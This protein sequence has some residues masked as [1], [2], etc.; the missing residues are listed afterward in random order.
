MQKLA[1][2]PL[3]EE[4]STRILKAIKTLNNS[5]NE[6][7]DDIRNAVWDLQEKGHL[8]KYFPMEQW[9]QA[10]VLFI[11]GGVPE[12]WMQIAQRRPQEFPT[13]KSFEKWPEQDYTMYNLMLSTIVSLTDSSLVASQR[14]AELGLVSF[15]VDELNALLAPEG[16][17]MRRDIQ[18]QQLTT[19][20]FNI[21]QHY[22][23]AV[24]QLREKGGVQLFT[25]LLQKAEYA[26][27]AIG[28][29]F[30]VSLKK[31]KQSLTWKII[32]I[33]LLSQ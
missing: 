4:Y 5:E 23:P 3:N 8:R 6:S 14:C 13:A 20:L 32:F 29:E 11:D 30:L 1:P 28:T 26:N 21:M 33:L 12:K 27:N 18:V 22:T 10:A 31:I 9:E 17:S 19:F 7:T 16:W 24:P 25:S 2:K 15:A